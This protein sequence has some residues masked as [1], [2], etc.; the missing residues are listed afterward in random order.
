MVNVIETKIFWSHF[1]GSWPYDDFLYSMYLVVQCMTGYDYSIYL[2]IEK[3]MH[4][5]RQQMTNNKNKNNQFIAEIKG[6]ATSC[7]FNTSKFHYR[8]MLVEGVGLFKSRPIHS[9]LYQN[10]LFHPI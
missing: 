3:M 7:S 1:K 5:L 6:K 4:D 10:S 9:S 8:M 2:V